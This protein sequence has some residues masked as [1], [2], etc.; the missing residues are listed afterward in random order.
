[1]HKYVVIG[2]MRWPADT[3]EDRQAILVALSSRQP[4]E[5]FALVWVDNDSIAT[6][7]EVIFAAA[8][9]LAAV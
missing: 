9:T 8:G 7:A 5:Q 3:P 2:E 6:A 1:M 4:A